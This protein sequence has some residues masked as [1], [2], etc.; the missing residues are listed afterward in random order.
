M[1]MIVESVYKIR[2]VV[3][4]EFYNSLM[5]ERERERLKI[6]T[7]RERDKEYREI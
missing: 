1:E 4:N 3:G 6:D 7:E 5:R 2:T